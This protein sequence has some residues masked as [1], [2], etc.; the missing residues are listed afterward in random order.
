VSGRGKPRRGRSGH[1]VYYPPPGREP[2]TAPEAPHRPDALWGWA[3]AVDIS[4]LVVAATAYIPGVPNPPLDHH[5]KCGNAL[6]GATPA[7]LAK[8]IPGA[9]YG[10]LPGDD[11]KIAAELRRRNRAGRQAW[12]NGLPAGAA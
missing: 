5:I 6:L 11:P 12:L 1:L 3:L 8:G 9:A 10:P 2:A 7:L 4:R